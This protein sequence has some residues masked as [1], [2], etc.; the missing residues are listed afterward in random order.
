MM[1]NDM[2]QITIDC[3]K[4]ETPG[5]LHSAFAGALEFPAWYGKNLD[6]L[7]D[8]LTSLSE[9]TEIILTAFSSLPGFANGFR[10]VLLDAEEENPNLKVSLL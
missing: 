5:Q 1:G 3:R 6:A 7:Y 8:C 9:E 10:R 2:K 4:I